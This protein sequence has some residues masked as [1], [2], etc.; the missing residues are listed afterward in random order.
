M[1]VDAWGTLTYRSQGE[2]PLSAEAEY[3]YH[4]EQTRAD[5]NA[6]VECDIRVT[7]DAE[8]FFVTGEYRALEN[9]QLVRRRQVRVPVRR[10][11]V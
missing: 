9:N 11:F 8:Y 4:I 1:E 3:R 6:C 7:A 2:D 10:K 5:W